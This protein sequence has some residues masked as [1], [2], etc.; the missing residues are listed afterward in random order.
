MDQFQEFKIRDETI[1]KITEWVGDLDSSAKADRGGWKAIGHKPVQVW[2]SD[3]CYENGLIN[4]LLDIDE[5]MT[6]QSQV[7]SW[8]NRFFLSTCH[9]SVHRKDIFKEKHFGRNRF[10]QIL[11][12]F[13]S[14]EEVVMD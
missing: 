5:Y 10:M 7:S 12:S 3:E 4:F 14:E 13:C 6:S 1:W 9:K 2:V 8:P 11:K